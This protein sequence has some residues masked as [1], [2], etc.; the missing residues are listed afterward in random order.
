[1]IV[2]EVL[3][4]QIFFEEVFHVEN[5]PD[6]IK[7]L[8]FL[9]HLAYCVGV[10]LHVGTQAPDLFP[11]RLEILETLRDTLDPNLF[12][13]LC[14]LFACYYI[15]FIIDPMIDNNKKKPTMVILYNYL[16]DRRKVFYFF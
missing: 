16:S 7:L 12:N 4:T 14:D 2:I 8:E 10:C 1:M 9:S 15:S 13:C 6:K 11:L 3:R 5:V